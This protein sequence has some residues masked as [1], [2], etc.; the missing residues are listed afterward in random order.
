MT[1]GASR[2][3]WR[4]GELAGRPLSARERELLEHVAAGETR[5][6]IA[7]AC[8]ISVNTV[9]RHLWGIYRKLEVDGA[10]EAFIKL[11]WLKVPDR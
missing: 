8:Q 7:I 11:G 6:E 5:K 1:V 4:I 10:V 9:R 3:Q 2:Y